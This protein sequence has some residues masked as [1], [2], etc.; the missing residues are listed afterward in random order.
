GGWF[1]S[2]S[3]RELKKFRIADNTL[4]AGQAFQVFY[5]SQFNPT[6]GSSIPF[7]F[8]S[9]HGD[10]AYLSQADANGNLTGYRAAVSF[11]AAANGVSFGRYVNSLGQEQFVA[12][13]ARSFGMDNPATVD[14]FHSGSGAA[15]PAPLVGPVVLNEIMFYPPPNLAEDDTQNEF[16]ELLNVT[17]EN[18]PLFDP[19]APTNT[20]K[21]QG[22][23]D[24]TFPQNV[25]LPPGG[26]VLL[27]NFDP[28]LDQ[29]ALAT[30]RVR[31]NLSSS[32]PLFGP[33]SGRLSNSGENLDLYR[34]DVPQAAPHPD[35]GFVPY[36]LVESINYLAAAPWP[37]GADG[38]GAS[39]QR[40]V[41][42]NYGNDP[43]NWLVA[44]PTAGRLNS[45]NPDDT[46]SDGLPDAWQTQYFSS[47]TAPQAAPGADPD[48]DGFNNLQE[49]LAGTN[50]NLATSY[51]KIDS[52]QVS[53]S[54]RT[55]SFT[56]VAGKTY[57][58][59]Y[60]TSLEDTLWQRLTNVAAQSVS[61]PVNIPEA[62]S[63][64]PTRF[65]RLVTP[66][67]P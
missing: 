27:V 9:A 42:A 13:S 54:N 41:A 38:T 32:V 58:I 8:N 55:I 3:K 31:Y 59:L 47:V 66:Q 19:L 62:A 40:N 45:V 12:M 14:Q 6:N 61:G 25:T 30:F 15:N 10:R 29:A 49:Y 43:A 33:Y 37:A 7:T 57:T 51:L 46:N 21:I 1:L 16:L 63:G 48:G 23:V 60:K 28:V 18:V 26:T 52:V 22:G 64:T 67:L 5:E 4:V 20:W 17:A 35:A 65:Y 36:I 34:P 53:G 50:P 2:N 24:Y 39:L 44:A 56:A 11:G